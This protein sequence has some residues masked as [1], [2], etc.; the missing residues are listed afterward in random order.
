[1]NFYFLFFIHFLTSRWLFKICYFDKL[2]S[3]LN[4]S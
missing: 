2:S 3:M 1:M 4:N